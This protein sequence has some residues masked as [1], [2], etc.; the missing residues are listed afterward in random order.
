MQNR[1][2]S[3]GFTTFSVTVYPQFVV[4]AR[5]WIPKVSKVCFDITSNSPVGLQKVPNHQE[6]VENDGDVRCLLLTRQ[7]GEDSH[8][9]S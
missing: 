7:C 5:F 2:D 8:E 9:R 4:M 3:L 1:G 6:E